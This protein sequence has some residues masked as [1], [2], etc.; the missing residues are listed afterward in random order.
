MTEPVDAAR[1]LL[2]ITRPSVE[3]LRQQ[4]ELREYS[5]SE[6]DVPDPQKVLLENLD[7]LTG[8][9]HVIEEN[10]EDAIQLVLEWPEDQLD[11]VKER[12]RELAKPVVT[13]GE[14]SE[15]GI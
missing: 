7:H 4:R 15:E 9:E 11:E 2:R 3:E 13:G 12:V 5:S 10:V 14:E 1:S 8:S 6:V